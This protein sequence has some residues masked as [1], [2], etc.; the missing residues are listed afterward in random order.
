MTPETMRQQMLNAETVAG[1]CGFQP[2]EP[3]DIKE[4]NIDTGVCEKCLKIFSMVEIKRNAG[5]C[6]R[7]CLL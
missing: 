1:W 5:I 7:C 2:L 3:L 6:D 4:V